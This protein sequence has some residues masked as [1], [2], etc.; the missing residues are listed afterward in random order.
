MEITT[1][2]HTI[3]MMVGA[4][5][6]GKSTFAGKVLIPGLRRENAELG[7][8]ANVQYLSSDAIRQEL[9]GGDY[10]KYDQVMLE[11]SEP[12]FRLLLD[13][14]KLLTS[15]PVNAEFV[16]VDTTGL[17]E[18][19]RSQVRDIAA[20]NGYR[21]EVVLFDYRK[22]EDYYASE[23][24]KRI[25]SNHLNR[26]RKEVLPVLSREGY[27]KIHKIRAKDF[28]EPSTG[29]SNPDYRVVVEDW[30]DYRACVLSEDKDYVVVGDVHECVDEL[31]SLLQGYGFRIDESGLMTP[32][33]KAA[34]T[35]VILVGDWIDKGGR[36]SDIV[37]FLHRNRKHFRFVLGNHENFVYK[38]VKGEIAGAD[39]S[40]MESYFA[41]AIVLKDDEQLFGQFSELV[42][43]SKPF[44]RL[45]GSAGKPSF[46]VTHAPCRNK[47]VGK[48]S[49]EAVRHQRNFRLDRE[50]STDEQLAFL[51]T[52]A[53]RNHPYH[54]FGHVA[55]SRSFSVGNKMHLDTG[56]VH[57]NALTAVRVSSRLQFKSVKAQKAI[58]NEP[59]PQLFR[60]EKQVSLAELEGESLRRLHYCSHNGINF[61]SGTMSP[62]DKDEAAGELESLR[63]GLDYFAN[64]GASEV[65]LQP[66][67]MGSRC[68]V[69]LSRDAESSYAV[70][71]NGYKV[72][73]VELAPVYGRLLE[74]FGAYMETE[75]VSL[76]ILDGELLPWRAMGEGLIQRQFEPIGKALEAEIAFLKENGFEEA[77]GRLSDAFA[78]SGF[79]QDQHR[80]AKG[81]L[82]DKYGSHVYQTY[83]YVASSRASYVPLDQHGEALR[84]Y[85]RQL[86]LYAGDGELEFK[87]FA[88]LKE[89]LANGEERLPQ[90]KTS[91]LYRF[92]NDD[93][94]LVLDLTQE[95]SYEKA[96][97]FFARLT[98]ENGM[99]GVVIKPEHAAF[100]PVAKGQRAANVGAGTTERGAN[101]ATIG[102]ERESNGVAIKP[103]REPDVAVAKGGR[104][105]DAVVSGTERTGNGVVPYLK[106]RNPGYLSIIYGYDYRFPHKYAKLIKQKN[107]APKLRTSLKEH[108]LGGQMLAIKLADISP[109]N[110]E[111]KQIAANLLF[112]VARESEIDPRL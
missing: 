24:S 102:T 48:L 87:P 94:M 4:T 22:R 112:E 84:V 96:A 45:I 89:V 69:Y 38:Y 49:P 105:A 20:Q 19:F 53:V 77:W 25:I 47:Y 95:G 18:D 52:E 78:S 56:C 110:K 46:Y 29:K 14:L 57:G 13:K 35:E 82:N 64:R 39:K 99:E 44:Y 63:K 34:N 1:S 76:M 27:D 86:E 106:V 17:M 59:L 12:A 2:V 101:G 103:E 71:R 16:V 55:A 3:F 7:L 61:I 65:V 40:L 41:S 8:R 6:C 31:A 32:G 60:E 54:L 43:A 108:R 83:K 67:Y 88:L 73:G 15:F 107:I 42:E 58:V 68:T 80:M 85:G 36:T 37:G 9:L 97:Q 62:A 30:E 28:Y 51:K 74:R 5:E 21:L 100:V 50:A 72:K 92:L 23:R 33:D 111:F 10:D 66:K 90:L 70:S 26:L 75:G 109:D 98:V 93:E 91:E 11:A 81:A 79:E 104:T